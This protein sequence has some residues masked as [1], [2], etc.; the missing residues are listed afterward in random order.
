MYA[1]IRA[2]H[3]IIM[4]AIAESVG[5]EEYHG[6]NGEAAVVAEE[7][8]TYNNVDLKIYE[9]ESDAS[10]NSESNEERMN[11][12]ASSSEAEDSDE[13]WETHSD[14]GDEVVYENPHQENECPMQDIQ[15]SEFGGPIPDSTMSSTLRI[16]VHPTE[17]EQPLAE[18]YAMTEMG[19]HSSPARQGTAKGTE[20]TYQLPYSQR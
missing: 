11:C 13:E 14:S 7:G 19:E 12:I 2:V 4:D 18:V 10:E 3:S 5:S 9:D 6:S 16:R 20:G 17:V 15:L 1:Q 8:D